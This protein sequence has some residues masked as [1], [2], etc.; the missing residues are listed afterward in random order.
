MNTDKLA[1]IC[2]TIDD[3]LLFN[4]V[5]PNDIYI[6]TLEEIVADIDNEKNIIKQTKINEYSKKLIDANNLYNNSQKSITKLYDLRYRIN[7][8]HDAVNTYN[9]NK[10][11]IINMMQENRN[12]SENRSEYDLLEYITS[13]NNVIH[14]QNKVLEAIDTIPDIKNEYYS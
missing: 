1:N 8:Y 7:E 10:L 9:N 2:Q 5:F 13:K 6:G 3:H 12:Y 14:K 4:H 11:T